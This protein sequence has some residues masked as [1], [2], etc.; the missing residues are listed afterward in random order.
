MMSGL[1]PRGLH[2]R[3][4][5]FHCRRSKRRCDK[6]LPRCNICTHNGF[7]CSYPTRRGEQ[8][9]DNSTGPEGLSTHNGHSG[10]SF[11]SS[12]GEPDATSSG[13]AFAAAVN[14]IAPE[15]FH[16]AQLALLLPDT[17]VP[18]DV[19]AHI[20]DADSIRNVAAMFFRTIHTWLPIISK[21]RFYSFVLNPLSQRGPERS[22]LVL[23]MKLCCSPRPSE[24]DARSALYRAA[25]RFYF[26]VEASGLLS[27]H[28]M[29][30][31]LLIAVYEMGQ[32]IYP[33]AFLTVGACARYGMA[34]G[35]QTLSQDGA[36]DAARQ[37]SWLEVE[38]MR[39]AWWAV[40]L[41]DR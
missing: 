32:A 9:R 35:I 40:L 12:P 24:G 34:L 38:E 10:G 18:A 41:L 1:P 17:P 4:A 33:A 11:H 27:I 26:E 29:Q 23:C 5:C 7:E 20:G 39:R 16:Q 15:V 13:A 25:K 2:A 22:L 19:A 30:A 28:V 6:V 21:K 31:G 37:R 3:L 14:F 8:S 36:G